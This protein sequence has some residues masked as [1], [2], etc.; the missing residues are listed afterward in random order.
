MYGYKNNV[1]NSELSIDYNPIKKILLS[2]ELNFIDTKLFYKIK[3]DNQRKLD[4]FVSLIF[5]FVTDKV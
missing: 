2:L 4:K 5:F 1:K 3:F